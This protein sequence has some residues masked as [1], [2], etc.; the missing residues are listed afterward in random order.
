MWEPEPGWQPLPRGPG[1]ATTGVWRDGDRVV[2]R[3]SAPLSGDPGWLVDPRHPGWWR[4]EA[5]VALSGALVGT[6]GLRTPAAIAVEEDHAGVTLAW[7][8]LDAEPVPGPFA[9]H[10]L[11]R[12]AAAELPP[13]PWLVEHQLAVRLAHVERRGGW[14]LLSRTT[15]A[16]VADR[17]W[18]RRGTWLARLD[19]LPQ[20]PQHGDPTP[21]NLVR[22]AGTDVVAV[23]WQTFG[24]GP[25]GGDLGYWALGARESFEVL[26]EAYADGLPRDVASPADVVLGAGVT[27]VYTALSRADWAL[28]Q[29]AG[30]EGA[31]AGKFR[32]PAVAPHLRTLQRLFP[33]V[34]AL[35]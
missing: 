29:A 26:A 3:L 31:L 30:G 27:A 28:G 22:P 33:Q 4:R 6:P 15:V 25:V 2:K 21:G 16:D 11:G 32:H 12:F 9:A 1:A 34:E 23:D 17:L 7:P 13:Y 10:A 35:L 14:R 24:T 5:E 18:Q 8:W 20:V 19:A